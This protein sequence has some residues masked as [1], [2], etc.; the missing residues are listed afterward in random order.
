MKSVKKYYISIIF[1][2]LCS[3]VAHQTA[4]AQKTLSPKDKNT[5]T[6]FEKSAK[7]YSKLREQLEEKLPKLPK[8]ATPEQIEAHKAAFQKLVRAARSSA[9]QGDIFTPAAAELI[10]TIIK[11]E[12]KGKDRAEL[13]ETVLE[14]D[15]KG[16]L[17]KINFPYPDSKEQTEMPPTLLLNF[18]QLP[19]QLRFRFVGRN[20]LLLDRENGL[21]VD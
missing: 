9:K 14:A 17:L 13:R 10:R 18:P 4:T 5:T 2:L 3:F 15:T 8:D 1:L 19:K 6:E 7:E 11:S 16:I 20:L 21:I 12:F